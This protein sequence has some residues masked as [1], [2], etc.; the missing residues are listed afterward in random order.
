MAQNYRL[1]DGAVRWLAGAVRT[2]QKRVEMLETKNSFEHHDD[3]SVP[4]HKPD[5][6]VETGDTNTE[7]QASKRRK[8]GEW[9][10]DKV[11]VRRQRRH[12]VWATQSCSVP[13]LDVP[14]TAEP[15][16]EYMTSAPTTE[17]V[18]PPAEILAATAVPVTE[19][20]DLLEPS[21]SVDDVP[22]TTAPE[23]EYVT[24]APTTEFVTPPVVI[25]DATA[26]PE[27]TL[28]DLLEPNVPDEYAVHAPCPDAALEFPEAT[29]HVDEYVTSAPTA[30]FVT[31][32]AAILDATAAPVTTLISWNRLYQSNT[33]W[34]N[35]F[36]G[37]ILDLH[38]I[39]R[40]TSSR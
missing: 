36:R 23:D 6:N 2:L 13:T 33:L 9:K 17:F 18:T 26:M 16:D 34:R 22:V 37:W 3:T 29:A 1:T 15:A 31:Q 39:M 7:L 20:Y 32:A 35:T 11:R 27:A 10:Y 25:L 24:F 4:S 14:V 5:D 21:V 8:V 19:M 28:S 30:E 40:D 38:L 12:A